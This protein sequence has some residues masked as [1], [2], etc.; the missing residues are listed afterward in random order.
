MVNIGK[1][2]IHGLYMDGTGVVFFS[3]KKLQGQKDQKQKNCW[4]TSLWSS[5]QMNRWILFHVSSIAIKAD[6][7]LV[8]TTFAEVSNQPKFGEKNNAG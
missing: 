8:Q 3:T 5:K 6:A 7:M 2:T 4:E 1:Y